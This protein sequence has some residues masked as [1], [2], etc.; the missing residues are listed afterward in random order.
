MSNETSLH[1]AIDIITRA[2]EADR[3]KK[4]DE[5][6][7]YYKHGVDYLLYACKYEAQNDKQKATIRTRA[8]EYLERA[9]KIKKYL[10]T[11]KLQKPKI[12]VV[13]VNL[14]KA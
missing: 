7:K 12:N 14:E 3:A 1:K 5:A 10:S 6:L 8:E 4:Y 2:T 13:T 9:E 11:K